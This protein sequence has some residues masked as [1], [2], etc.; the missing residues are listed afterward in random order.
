LGD[1]TEK[2]GFLIASVLPAAASHA[3]AAV[4]SSSWFTLPKMQPAASKGSY[5][6][7]EGSHWF[8]LFIFKH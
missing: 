5:D 2:E 3:P 8:G 6:F 7:G 1:S 4:A